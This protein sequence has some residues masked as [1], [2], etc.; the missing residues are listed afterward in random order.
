MKALGLAFL[1]AIGLLAYMHDE[2]LLAISFMAMGF[3]AGLLI[4]AGIE[5]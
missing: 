3:A 1:I 4:G 5:S 2:Y